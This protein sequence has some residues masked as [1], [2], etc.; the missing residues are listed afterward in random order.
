M[1]MNLSRFPDD[2][3]QRFKS[4]C[5]D[6]GVIRCPPPKKKYCARPGW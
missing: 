2:T 1:E 4:L 3:F 6:N 5:H